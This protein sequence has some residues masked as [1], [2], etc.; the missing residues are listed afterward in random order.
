MNESRYEYMVGLFVVIGLAL[1]A[2][3][4]LNF[5][6]GVTLGKSTYKLRVILPSAAG[7]KPAADVM[8]SGVAVGKVTDMTL[9][10]D[11]KSV[12]ITLS[13]LSKY[14]IRSDAEFRVD[15]L[16]FLGDQYVSVV[17]P[18]ESGFSPTNEISYLRNGDTVVGEAPFNMQEAVHSIS[19]VIDQARKTIKDLDQAITNI[20]A[21]ALSTNTLSHFVRAVSN[22]EVVSTRAVGA[23]GRV[24][25]LLRTNEGPL[26]AAVS[27]FEVVSA[28]LTN[29]AA[30]LDQIIATNSGE[31]H[32]V[33]TN[34]TAASY[35]IKQFTVDLRDTNGPVAALLKDQHLKAEMESAV[36][37]A[38]NMLTEFSIFGHNLNE[39]G[40]WR[41]L[42]KPKPAKGKEKDEESS[43]TRASG[44][45]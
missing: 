14:K 16:N 10:E 30:Q 9:A 33:V 4:I 40:I 41:M 34:L 18:K 12:D 23:A 6:Q 15:S 35:E 38:N 24:E 37:N 7:L 36:S 13:I 26:T 42:W 32:T 19:G 17:I 29:S 31:V 27:N 20:N 39:K 1:L 2:L 44:G 21:S 5:S 28:T 3:L 11:T 25:D 45:K 22:L 43:S 8:M